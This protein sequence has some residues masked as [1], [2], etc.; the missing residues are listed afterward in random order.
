MEE[1]I[2]VFGVNWKLLVIQVVNFGILLLVLHRF[3]YR[4]LLSLMEKRQQKIARG[5]SD[6]EEAEAKLKKIEE[7]RAETMKNSF[8][9]GERVVKEA[10][11]RARSEERII[12]EEAE[13]R[14]A[15]IV[16]EA[17]KSAEDEKTKIL[18]ETREEIARM[19]ILGAERILRG[20]N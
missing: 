11:Q 16:A 2:K 20:R 14:S 10:K 17:E 18:T 5:L 6:A 3:L 19:A 15:R 13:D 8:I 1:I 7:E 12:I 4:P 9:E